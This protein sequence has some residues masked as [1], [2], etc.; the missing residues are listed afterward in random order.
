M[1]ARSSGPRFRPSKGTMHHATRLLLEN[2]SYACFPEALRSSAEDFISTKKKRS[3]TATNAADLYRRAD[4]SRSLT[5]TKDILKHTQPRI[6]MPPM[7]KGRPGPCN[8]ETEAA[9]SPQR[10]LAL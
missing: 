7:V 3:M 1:A 4:P 5:K 9:N 2:N 8:S 6:C 10:I